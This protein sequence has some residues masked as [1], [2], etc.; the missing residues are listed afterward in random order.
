MIIHSFYIFQL[1]SPVLGF[2]IQ[3]SIN[4]ERVYSPTGALYIFTKGKRANKHY[5]CYDKILY[6]VKRWYKTGTSWSILTVGTE[7]FK[8]THQ[9]K[10]PQINF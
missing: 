8:Q 7:L 3:G 6:S 2:G 1:A 5:S 10:D 4:Q 9:F